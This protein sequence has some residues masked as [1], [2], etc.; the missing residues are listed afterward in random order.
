VV[1]FWLASQSAAAQ[2]FAAIARNPAETGQA[3]K[4]FFILGRIQ[5]SHRILIEPGIDS[6]VKITAANASDGKSRW[7]AVV[8]GQVLAAAVCRREFTDVP[9]GHGGWESDSQAAWRARSA[10]ATIASA[11]ASWL[12]LPRA[13]R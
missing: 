11:Q 12:A 4:Q 2:Q 6:A 13:R 9:G 5:L 8:A 3:E 1:I 7:S 10:V